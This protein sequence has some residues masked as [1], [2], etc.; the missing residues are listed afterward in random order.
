LQWTLPEGYRGLI[1]DCDGTLIDS[2]PLHY[3][4]FLAV[5]P[6]HNLHLPETL[7]YQW[8]GAPV[9]E[10]IRRLAAEKGLTVDARAIA[11]ERD[12]YFHSLP[13]SALR[14]VKA[15]VEIAR[16]FHRRLPMAVATGSTLES[17]E[18]SLRAIGV[19]DLF[20]A[21][22]SSQHVGRPKPAPDVFLKAAERINIDPGECVAFEDADAGLQ[23]ARAAGMF[24]VDIRPWLER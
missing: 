1:F 14:P 7:F 24:T 9:D 16:H 15:V 3:Q 20:D 4:A 5:L 13:P 8:A 11:N 2:M 18:I 17:A 12:A 19:Y 21:V 23:A 10:V 22:I 6:R